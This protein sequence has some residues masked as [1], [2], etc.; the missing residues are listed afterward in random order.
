VIVAKHSCRKC[1]RLTC[2]FSATGHLAIASSL[3]MLG[4]PEVEAP[5]LTNLPMAHCAGD[6]DV[7]P[8]LITLEPAAKNRRS[9]KKVD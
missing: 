5:R 1:E 2:R 9:V 3:H 8:Y 4:V 7:L 6:H